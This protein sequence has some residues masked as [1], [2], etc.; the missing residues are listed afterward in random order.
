MDV[1]GDLIYEGYG[2]SR[3]VPSRSFLPREEETAR[4]TRP[5]CWSSSAIVFEIVDFPV[6]A[7]PYVLTVLPDSIH[8]PDLLQHPSMS[9]RFTMHVVACSVFRVS[10]LW[11][12]F[13]TKWSFRMSKQ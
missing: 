6:P 2:D 13:I 7:R 5:I 11:S 8:S 12:A 4:K 10:E 9:A 1:F 3:D